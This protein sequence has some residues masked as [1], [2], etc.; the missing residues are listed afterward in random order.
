MNKLP[1]EADTPPEHLT[2]KQVM[3]MLRAICKDCLNS[4]P[5]IY[6]EEDGVIYI[7]GSY[8]LW[9]DGG[10]R[11]QCFAKHPLRG[12]WTPCYPMGQRDPMKYF[13]GIVRTIANKKYAEWMLIN[14]CNT[15]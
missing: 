4:T 9:K 7:D 13:G 8:K 10:T 15:A 2:V 1:T 3:N 11:W 6:A 12:D 5:T 14:Y